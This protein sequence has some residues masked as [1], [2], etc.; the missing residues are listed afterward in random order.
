L[1]SEWKQ[2]PDEVLS[3]F[4]EYFPVQMEPLNICIPIPDASGWARR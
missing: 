2:P 3:S 1:T 4:D